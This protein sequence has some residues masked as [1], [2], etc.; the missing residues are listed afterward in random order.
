MLLS[1]S[2]FI[3][4]TSLRV[5]IGKL[6]SMIDLITKSNQYIFNVFFKYF[7]ANEVMKKLSLK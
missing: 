7:L 2:M 1:L 5:F 4:T 6:K 3:I